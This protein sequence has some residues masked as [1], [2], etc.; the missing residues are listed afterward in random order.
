MTKRHMEAQWITDNM[1]A[2]I[3]YWPGG[4]VE[5]GTR[6]P[7]DKC[8]V[9]TQ[10]AIHS[11]LPFLFDNGYLNAFLTKNSREEDLKVTHRVLDILAHEVGMKNEGD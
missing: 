11:L 9:I 1:H 7:R 2:E 3:M 5:P 6:I 4:D 10:F 8:I